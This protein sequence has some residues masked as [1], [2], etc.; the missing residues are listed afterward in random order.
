MSAIGSVLTLLLNIIVLIHVGYIE[1]WFFFKF[2][3][4]RFSLIFL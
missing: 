4:L 1:I 3:G 2:T